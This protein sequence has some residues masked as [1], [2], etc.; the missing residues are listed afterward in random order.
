MWN[1]PPTPPIHLPQSSVLHH[2]H[3]SP[4]PP[5]S[6]TDPNYPITTIHKRNRWRFCCSIANDSPI[7]PPISGEFNSLPLLDCVIVGAG[8][9]DLYIAESLAINTLVCLLM[10]WLQKHEIELGEIYPRLNEMVICGKKVLIAFN[11]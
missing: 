11:R 2:L 7:S 5:S 3:L 1:P 4:P 8:I 9:N 6:L 10:W